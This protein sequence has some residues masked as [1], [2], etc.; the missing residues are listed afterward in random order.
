[1]AGTAGTV[2]LTE[3]TY[4][5][6][7]KI[8]AE[9]TSGTGDY[10]GAASGTTTAA[11]DGQILALVT[12]PDGDD[13]P[14]DNYDITLTDADGIDVLWGAGADRDTANTEYV[15]SGL[16]Y[17]ANSKLTFTIASAGDA[18]EGVAYIYIR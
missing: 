15:T 5:V 13:A 12:D 2:T 17:V 18:K 16:G 14:S 3:Q 11:F 9:W 8:K 1:M 10:A 6:V 4:S 7:K